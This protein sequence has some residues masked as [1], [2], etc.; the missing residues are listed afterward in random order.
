MLAKALDDAGVEVTSRNFPG[1]THEFFGT[2][3]VADA[4]TPSSLPQAAMDPITTRSRSGSL[5]WWEWRHVTS[6]ATN[7]QNLL[8]RIIASI[9]G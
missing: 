6:A 9:E 7:C 8:Q 4:S 3:V 5:P 1:S 2:A